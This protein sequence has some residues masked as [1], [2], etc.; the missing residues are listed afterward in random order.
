MKRNIVSGKKR[1]F[2]LTNMDNKIIKL[3]MRMRKKEKVASNTCTI[4]V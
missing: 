4:T 3:L 2:I 1:R